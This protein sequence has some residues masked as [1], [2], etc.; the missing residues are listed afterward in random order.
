MSIYFDGT[1]SSCIEMM[2]SNGTLMNGTRSTVGQKFLYMNLLNH[3]IFGKIKS[4]ISEILVNV[5]SKI[6][7]A[8]YGVIVYDA[9]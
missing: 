4:T 3:L 7:P 2:K 9:T 1:I 8:I 6:T 5:F